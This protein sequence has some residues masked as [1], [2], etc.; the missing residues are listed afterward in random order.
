MTRIENL[1]AADAFF[2][3]KI[4]KRYI[5]RVEKERFRLQPKK[6]YDILYQKQLKI[7]RK[8]VSTKGIQF[9][10]WQLDLAKRVLEGESYAER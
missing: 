4:T 7:Q 8:K 5:N 9:E 2:N 3:Q 1:M 6:A 10:Q